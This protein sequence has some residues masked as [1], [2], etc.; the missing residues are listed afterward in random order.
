MS[1]LMASFS[2]LHRPLPLSVTNPIGATMAEEWASRVGAVARA[3]LTRSLDQTLGGSRFLD[4]YRSAAT[5]LFRELSDNDDIDLPDKWPEPT[6]DDAAYRLIEELSPSIARAIDDAA[7]TVKLPFWSTRVVRN[8]LAVLLLT[9]TVAAFVAGIYLPHPYSAWCN[10][11]L[12]L[13][14]ISGPSVVRWARSDP[15]ASK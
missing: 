4:T 9:A 1:A 6:A 7:A 11:A 14:G 12:G 5:Q 13:S 10:A 2:E 15:P 3:S 8:T